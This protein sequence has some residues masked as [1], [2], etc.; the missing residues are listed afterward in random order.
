VNVGPLV[1][2]DTKASKLIEP[3][4]C[5]LDDPAPSSQT[6]AVLGTAHRQQRQDAASSQ[7]GS[8]GLC[9]VAAVSHHRIWATSR[10]SPRALEWRNRIHQRQCLLRVVSVGAGQANRERHAPPVADQMT[11]APALGRSVGFGPVWSPPQTARTEQLST[12]ASDQ[13]IWS[14]RASQSSSAKCIRSQTPAR[15]QSRRRRQHVIRPAPEFLRKHLPGNSAA[16]DEDDAR[17]AR[18]IRNTWSAT[19]WPPCKNRQEGFDKIPQPIWKQRRGHT[20]FTLL[21]RRRSGSVGFV[22]RSKEK[23]VWRGIR[24]GREL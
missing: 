15:C 22:T 23:H 24:R 3:R 10:P 18:A 19:L 13:S 12:T 20:P 17:Q 5:P 21:R 11:L 16:K 7:P 14:E 1:V 6:A 2:A 9:I 8:D 4:K